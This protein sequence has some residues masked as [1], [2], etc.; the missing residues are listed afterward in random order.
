MSDT[1]KI[2]WG[3]I[4][5][6][7]ISRRR[8]APAIRDMEH[9]RLYAV[10]RANPEML[11][12]FAS[13]FHVR[14]V[15]A[16]W[17]EMIK[18]PDIHAVYIATPVH[19][20]SEMT[21]AAAHAGKHV[22]CEKPMAMS[23]PECLKMIDACESYEVRLGIA[24]YR[25]LYPVI[26]RCREIMG[27]G[28][29]GDPTIVQIN[30]FSHFD[31]QPGEARYWLLEKE[32]S[33]GGPMMDFGCHRIEVM[34]DL[35]GPIRTVRS[36]LSNLKYKR[37]VEDTAV[38]YFEFENG[39]VGIL[40]VTHSTFENRDTVQIFGTQGSIHI[41][42]LNEGRLMLR[43]ASGDQKEHLPPH[44]NLHMP[45]IEDF[46]QAVLRNREPAVNGRTGLEV[47]R[48]LSRI[49]EHEDEQAG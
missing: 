47:N 34:L 19:L 43:T 32:K 33:G 29:I 30:A 31:R 27:Q 12:S 5:C 48:I 3:L 25:H 49:Y 11:E 4:G 17:K 6:G 46:T 24:Y 42:V 40:A 1:E 22:L 14:K 36:V 13:E 21:I 7:D 16:N 41:P 35:L 39:A 45:L 8:I 23:V 18:D 37:D 26:G 20:H 44:N 10:S 28:L 2:N 38:A 9:G 15:Y